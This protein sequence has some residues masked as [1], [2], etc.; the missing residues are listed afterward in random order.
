MVMSEEEQDALMSRM[1]TWDDATSAASSARAT[2]TDLSARDPRKKMTRSRNSLSDVLGTLVVQEAQQNLDRAMQFEDFRALRMEQERQRDRLTAWDLKHKKILSDECDARKE[3]TGPAFTLQAEE[4][5]EQHARMVAQVEDKHVLDEADLRKSHEAERRSSA[6]ALRHMEAYCRGETT[7][8]DAHNR[9]ITDQ[10][11]RELSKARYSRDQMDA[12]Q[13]GAINVL[14]GEQNRRMSLRLHKQDQ[15]RMQLDARQY[16]ELESIQRDYDDA[17]RAWDQ[18]THKMKARLQDWWYL[19]TEIWRKRLEKETEVCIEGALLP[20]S[21]PGGAGVSDLDEQRQSLNGSPVK[22]EE[23]D[24]DSAG[25]RKMSTTK[26]ESGISS[27]FAVRSS[28]VGQA[29]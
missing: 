20:I 28:M 16:R 13:A 1:A 12:R 27:A 9:P 26:K 15:E 3:D 18:E 14:R 6:V 25:S 23:S 4:L 7:T 2:S 5:L 21:W 19:Q 10:D 8:G 11:L 24:G 29:R 22:K 17:L